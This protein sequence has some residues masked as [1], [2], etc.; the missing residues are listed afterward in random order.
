MKSYASVDEKGLISTSLE[1]EIYD[2]ETSKKIRYDD[3]ET[4]MVDI[5]TDVIEVCVGEI[6]DGDI[7]ILEHEDGKITGFYEKDDEEKQR[8]IKIINDILEKL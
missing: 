3:K 6:K 7:I 2:V 1:V 5:P 4:I 8:R